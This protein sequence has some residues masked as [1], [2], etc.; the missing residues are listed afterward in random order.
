[1]PWKSTALDTCIHLWMP[2]GEGPGH[3]LPPS[4]DM[5]CTHVNPARSCVFLKTW[6]A[7]RSSFSCFPSSCSSV[8][9]IPA[10]GWW[11]YW[12]QSFPPLLNWSDQSWP[13]SSGQPAMPQRLTHAAVIPAA[14]WCRPRPVTSSGEASSG[15]YATWLWSILVNTE[16][17]TFFLSQPAWLLVLGREVISVAGG[18][19]EAF[20]LEGIGDSVC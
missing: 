8:S 17:R 9:D 15:A 4:F 10:W 1:M 11:I 14:W 19:W 3:V 12:L 7:C 16:S 20:F 5:P 2:K 6:N 18:P 13:V